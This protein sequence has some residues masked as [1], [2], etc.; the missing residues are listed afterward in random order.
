MTPCI[1]SADT[2]IAFMQQWWWW[3]L[4]KWANNKKHIMRQI[5][6][7]WLKGMQ[8]NFIPIKG[9]QS[10]ETPNDEPG[11]WKGG[12]NRVWFLR[13]CDS[14]HCLTTHWVQT[15]PDKNK[16][17][18]ACQTFPLHHL[19]C[20]SCYICTKRCHLVFCCAQTQCHTYKHGFLVPA[21]QK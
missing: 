21:D 1:Q 10:S 5:N 9:Y 12:G 6:R 14:Q 4:V 2:S 19:R 13:W 3:Y 17:G 16:M 11:E 7:N 15:P 20:M 18:S 8:R